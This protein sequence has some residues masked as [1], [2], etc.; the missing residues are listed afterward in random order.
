MTRKTP[1][2]DTSCNPYPQID[3]P[4]NP[5]HQNSPDTIS[6]PNLVQ[7]I[8]VQKN[9]TQKGNKTLCLST[10]QSQVD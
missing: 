6:R 7:V 4:C 5:P 3:F 2:N 10:L 1:Q 9:R 8:P